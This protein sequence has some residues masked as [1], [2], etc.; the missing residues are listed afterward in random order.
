MSV[1]KVYVLWTNPLFQ[2]VLRVLLS[3]SSLMLVG[4]SNDHSLARVEIDRLAPDVVIVESTENHS[5][6]SDETISF[7]QSGSRV[8]RLSL[9]DND[10]SIY[11]HESR[12]VEDIEDL[13]GV[14][15]NTHD[16]SVAGDEQ[17]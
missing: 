6:S 11:R 2:E 17:P 3:E 5:E 1:R 16:E 13:I 7:L 8:I 12:T 4:H 15:M 9:A 14:M 10:L